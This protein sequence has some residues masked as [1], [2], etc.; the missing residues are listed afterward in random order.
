[1][2]LSLLILAAA[3]ALALLGATPMPAIMLTIALMLG[4]LWLMLAWYRDG[5]ETVRAATLAR[6]PLYLAWKI[7]VYLRFIGK[8]EQEWVR[9]RRDGED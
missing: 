9:T 1:M 6:I 5:R 8:R 2:S 7:P 3:A 4:S